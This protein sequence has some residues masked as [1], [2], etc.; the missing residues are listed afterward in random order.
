MS[1]EQQPPETEAMDVD[2]SSD[3]SKVPPHFLSISS[4]HHR[5]QVLSLYVLDDLVANTQAEQ[6]RLTRQRMRRASQTAK[7]LPYKP[8][9]NSDM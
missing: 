2:H 1:S 4:I 9:E 6:E 5:D 3:A 8:E 7:S